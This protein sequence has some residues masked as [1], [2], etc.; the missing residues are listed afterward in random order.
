MES[1]AKRLIKYLRRYRSISSMEIIKTFDVTRPAREIHLLRG[2]GYNI[3]TEMVERKR[4]D[5][6]KRVKYAVYWLDD[7]EKI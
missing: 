2:Q 3:R 7:D 4:R 6:G 1:V 5:T